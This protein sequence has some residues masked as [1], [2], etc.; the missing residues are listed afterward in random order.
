MSLQKI[1]W[2]FL[3]IAVGVSVVYIM[4]IHH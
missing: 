1:G 3:G 4:I 2:L